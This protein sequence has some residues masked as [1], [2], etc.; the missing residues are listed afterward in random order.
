MSE[1][2]GSHD[3]LDEGPI[4]LAELMK[5]VARNFKVKRVW[6]SYYN[7]TRTGTLN[8]STGQRVFLEFI[9]LCGIRHS[10]VQA[11]RRFV[12]KQNEGRE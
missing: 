11:Y 4:P 12:A 3:L 10:T 9:D 1:N 8:R 5:Y 6:Q 7:Y 2:N